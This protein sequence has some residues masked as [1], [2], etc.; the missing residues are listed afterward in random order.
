MSFVRSFRRGGR[1]YYAEV[2]NRRVGDKVRQVFIRYIGTK[3][4]SPPHKFEVDAIHAGALATGLMTKTLTPNDVFKVLDAQ[5]VTYHREQ[6][7]RIGIIYEFASKKLCVCLYPARKRAGRRG[8][9]SA[10]RRS[11]HTRPGEDRSSSSA[12]R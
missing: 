7:A 11:N 8:A 1:V 4:D 6:L 9:S 3:P 12:G 10:R 2:E 5:G